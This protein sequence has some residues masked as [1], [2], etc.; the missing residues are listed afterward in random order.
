M[1]KHPKKWRDNLAHDVEWGKSILLGE[2][3]MRPMFVL[4]N[5]DGS[6]TPF[7]AGFQTD[8]QKRA[9]FQFFSI[10]IVAQE[11]VGFSFLCEGWLKTSQQHADETAEEAMTRALA[12]PSP[13]QAE[14]RKEVLTTMLVYRDAADERQTLSSILELDR[15]WDGKIKG[16]KPECM[17]TALIE[18][19]VRDIM[20]EDPPTI[21]QVTACR[22]FC[23]KKAA[24]VMDQLNIVTLE[25]P[26]E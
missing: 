17:G 8:G 2:G 7:L 3:E 20:E 18:G 22:L 5:R 21:A 14:D 12:G 26:P 1:T 11:A 24:F 6:V 9:I 4:H 25:K 19:A 10:L 16:F 13:A 15:G 23:I